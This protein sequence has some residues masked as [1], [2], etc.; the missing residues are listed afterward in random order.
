MN[1]ENISGE[2]GGLPG[3]TSESGSKCTDI[4]EAYGASPKPYIFWENCFAENVS[5]SIRGVRKIRLAN[6]VTVR[7]AQEILNGFEYKS[8]EIPNF[9]RTDSLPVTDPQEHDCHASTR[10]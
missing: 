10:N 8:N 2:F 7:Q 4:Q 5:I 1:L 9:D 3:K 6:F